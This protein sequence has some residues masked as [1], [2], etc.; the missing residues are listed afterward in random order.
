METMEKQNHPAVSDESA[1][2]TYPHARDK[3]LEALLNQ[4]PLLPGSTVV[5]IQA[6]GGYLADGIQEKLQGNVELIC[7][8]PVKALNQRLNPKYVIVEDNVE[9][10]PSIAPE[11]VDVVLGLAGLHHS[12][13]QQATVNEAFR[14][15]KPGGYFAV[16]DVIDDSAVANWLNN[17]VHQ[18]NPNGHI[19]DFLSPGEASKLMRNSGFHQIHETIN[20]VPWVLPDENHLATFFKGLFGLTPAISEVKKAIPGY[21]NL[22][23]RDHQVEVEWQLIYAAAQKPGLSL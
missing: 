13:N 20:S 23:H 18:H 10:W 15:L 6:A 22:L 7:I 16:C 14:V 3:E 4:V 1:M 8:E 11:S 9:D 21:L 12:N 17:Y 2:K 19:G 5:D